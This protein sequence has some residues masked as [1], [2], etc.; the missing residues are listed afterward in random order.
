M[1]SNVGEDFSEGIT[2]VLD[3]LHLRGKRLGNGIAGSTEG[4]TDPGD[5]VL[6]S[7]S[8]FGP[9]FSHPR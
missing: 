2:K 5:R 8:R 9:G 7:L 6:H 4:L 3:C 1:V